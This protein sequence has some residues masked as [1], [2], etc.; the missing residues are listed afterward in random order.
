[1][2]GSKDAVRV[3]A[4]VLRSFQ[5]PIVVID[6]VLRASTGARLID[7]DSL[8]ALSDGQ[9]PLATMVTP[10]TYEAALL[11]GIPSPVGRSRA[12]GCR[13][14]VGAGIRAALV[15]GGHMDDMEFAVDVLHDGE[16]VRELRA[17]RVSA[18]RCTEPGVHCRRRSPSSRAR[19]S[20]ADACAAAQ[21]FVAESIMRGGELA[22]GRGAGPVHQLGKLWGSWR[23][24]AVAQPR[25]V[26]GLADALQ[27]RMHSGR[28]R[29][30]AS[31]SALQSSRRKHPQSSATRSTRSASSG[32]AATIASTSA[33]LRVASSRH[34]TAG[35]VPG[36]EPGD[37]PLDL[38][39]REPA[40]TCQRDQREPLENAVVVALL[41]ARPRRFR[42]QPELLVSSESPTPGR[43]L[44]A[45]RPLRCSFRPFVVTS[46]AQ[47]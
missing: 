46:W 29:G 7:D 18:R 15:T 9:L 24:L 12:S 44:R 16:T 20:I 30:P 13:P 45:V 5:P 42:Q 26:P 1:M 8:G 47:P 11:L 27:Q 25:R 19:A 41:A 22:G 43:V 14:F 10:N 40:L 17:P 31:S 2:L 39:H 37:E 6:P 28:P 36:L 21:R 3:V 35:D 33:S 23:G 32:P 4:E 38:R 34:R